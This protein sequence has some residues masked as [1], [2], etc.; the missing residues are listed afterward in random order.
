M[1]WVE[2]WKILIATRALILHKNSAHFLFITC[3]FCILNYLLLASILQYAFIVLNRFLND[4]LYFCLMYFLFLWFCKAHL[5]FPCTIRFMYLPDIETTSKMCVTP[6]VIEAFCTVTKKSEKGWMNKCLM[7]ESHATHTTARVIS[8]T[9]W[10]RTFV[11]LWDVMP[12]GK[13]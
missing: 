6:V 13:Q 7:W 10:R 2:G 4:L 12:L 8:V 1:K 9:V 11:Y 3:F 5:L